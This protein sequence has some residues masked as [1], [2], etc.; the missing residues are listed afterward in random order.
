MCCYDK[1]IFSTP[2][3]QRAFATHPIIAC[4]NKYYTTNMYYMPDFYSLDE[5][6]SFSESDNSSFSAVDRW[7]SFLD[8]SHFSFSFYYLLKISLF[9][10]IEWHMIHKGK[11]KKRKQQDEHSGL[12][13]SFVANMRYVF[14]Q[15]FKSRKI[16]LI[17]SILLLF[18]SVSLV[19]HLNATYL[20]CTIMIY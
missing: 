11:E 6:E 20:W 16:K 3:L 7:I 2:F 4:D 1:K 12:T 5:I 10:F 9:I 13:N 15:Y 18:Y 14:I 19:L 17:I 8:G